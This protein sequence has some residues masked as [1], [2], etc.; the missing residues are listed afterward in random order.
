MRFTDLG[1]HLNAIRD[2]FDIFRSSD[3]VFREYVSSLARNSQLIGTVS[4]WVVESGDDCGSS[5]AP[6]QIPNGC[7]GTVPLILARRN[8]RQFDEYLHRR[9]HLSWRERFVRSLFLPPRCRKGGTDSETPR[10]ARLVRS[11]S[12][13]VSTI[14]SK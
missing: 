2:G 3:I 5:I 11:A 14:T 8:Q 7:P 4:S 13:R 6:P 9:L 1:Y 12:T 10:S